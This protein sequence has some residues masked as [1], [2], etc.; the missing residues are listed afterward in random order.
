M[1]SRNSPRNSPRSSGRRR[2][3]SHPVLGPAGV[4]LILTLAV[5]LAAGPAEADT[6][7]RG[8]SVV[9]TA[10]RQAVGCLFLEFGQDEAAMCRGAE[11]LRGPE[12][13][14][15]E[16]C[17]VCVEKPYDRR[18]LDGDW[19][20]LRVGVTFDGSEP[21]SF[22][23]LGRIIDEGRDPA[24]STGHAIAPNVIHVCSGVDRAVAWWPFDRRGAATAHEEVGGLDADLRDGASIGAGLI[25]GAIVFDGVDDHA[26]VPHDPGGRLDFGTGDFS[27]AFW[28]RTTSRR[29]V[30][31]V[32]DKRRSNPYRGYHVYLYRGA[33][34]LQLADGSW[35]N[36]NA[37]HFPGA[38]V[39]DGEWH[40]V[41]VSV[42]RD[43]P[44]GLRFYVDGRLVGSADPRRRDGDLGNDGAA[45]L[46][47]WAVSG[48]G[49]WPGRLD[50][51]SL[52]DRALTAADARS[53][54]G[55]SAG[56]KCG[57]S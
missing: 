15:I 40:H 29:G 34:G 36:W 53:L 11:I 32:I 50:D 30:G 8:G 6:L 41:V 47:R 21:A 51:L 16:P 12:S 27:V 22:G 43:R 39:A 46:G 26:V 18:I 5:V 35:T 49:F 23:C 17:T 31:T 55:A 2:R 28:L 44:D 20:D 54:F 57:P 1:T 13:R 37:H 48:T 45:Y 33:V 10:D 25:K 4:A 14:F 56:G 3:R 19:S 9:W 42:D 24:V 52:Y 38:D 7:C